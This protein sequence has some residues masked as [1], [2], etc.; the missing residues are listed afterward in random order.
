MGILVSRNH[1]GNTLI[2]VSISKKYVKMG[3]Q[4]YAFAVVALA[5]SASALKCYVGGPGNST[6]A[7]TSTT[8]CLTL[9]VCTKTG[10]G[11]KAVYACGTK[12]TVETVTTCLCS[13][14]A[15]NSA[16]TQ[17]ATQATI[18]FAVA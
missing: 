5:A 3:I 9:D 8:D 7:I 4:Y 18:L 16:P 11:D 6:G 1:S 2:E 14:D 12:A 13:K 10:E 15:C 17:S